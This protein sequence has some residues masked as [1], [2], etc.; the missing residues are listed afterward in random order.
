[1]S[2]RSKMAR[3]VARRDELY[4]A[5]DADPFAVLLMIERQALPPQ[6]LTFAAERL[7]LRMQC[8]RVMLAVRE[9]AETHRRA[10]VREGALRGL[11]LLAGYAMTGFGQAAR[12]ALL[13]R[14]EADEN[15]L[16]RK[17]AA[18]LAEDARPL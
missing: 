11:D 6:L 12:E 7:P 1:M 10:Y 3:E 17:M 18:E 4:A 16:L 15:E 14:A 2:K 13:R 9:V 8:R 5:L